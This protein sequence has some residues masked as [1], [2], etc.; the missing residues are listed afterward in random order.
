MKIEE[1]FNSMGPFP[2]VFTIF[3]TLIM[4]KSFVMLLKDFD[5]SYSCQLKK[6]IIIY[7]IFNVSS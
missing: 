1:F 5:K 2:F 6:I 4:K 7:W 3:S